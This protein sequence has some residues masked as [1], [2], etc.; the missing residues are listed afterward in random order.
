[1]GTV[2]AM[3]GLGVH[4]GGMFSTLWSSCAMPLWRSTSSCKLSISLGS[5]LSPNPSKDVLRGVILLK[6]FLKEV[7]VVSKLI[8][9]SPLYKTA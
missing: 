2:N 5:T 1:M 8:A 6:E 3:Y 4:T 7:N 9:P